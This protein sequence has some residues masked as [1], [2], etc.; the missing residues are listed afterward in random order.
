MKIRDRYIA[1]TLLSYTLVVLV[2]WLSIY[3]F[4]NFLTE[5]NSV[6]QKSYTILS[7][8]KYIFLKMPEVT[9]SQASPVILLGCVLGMGHLATTNQLLMFRVSGVSILRITGITLKNALFFVITIIVIGE[10]LAPMSS[11]YAELGRSNALGSNSYI[12]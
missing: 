4:F 8:I 11:N 6:G 10:L 5:I 2:V 12:H 9:Y 1:K 3:S 7:A